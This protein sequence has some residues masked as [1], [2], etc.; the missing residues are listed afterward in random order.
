[1]EQFQFS[2]TLNGKHALRD[3]EHSWRDFRSDGLT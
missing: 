3:F 2:T 1:M